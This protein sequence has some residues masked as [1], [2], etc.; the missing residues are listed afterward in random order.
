MLTLHG[1][2]TSTYCTTCRMV[3]SLKGVTDFRIEPNAPHSAEQD[4]RHPWGKVPALTHDGFT[5]Y[6]TSAITTYL[7]TLFP[8]P[9]L[10]P[11]DVK[12]LARMTQW[13]SAYCDNV[14]K[15]TFP[16]II[17]RLIV[18]GRGGTPDEDLVART[19][20]AAPATLAVFDRALAET[21]WL[22]GDR[23]TLADLFIL[24]NLV[25]FGAT[26]EG[27][28]I[29]SQLPHLQGM[30]DRAMANPQLAATMA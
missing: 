27:K 30:V 7:D 1:T 10:Q 21:P 16:I 29:M 2:P 22:A 28:A 9:P 19:A 13:I 8:Q 26:P 5:V 12:A 17:E 15:V 3:L 20:E 14:P 25:F 6:E 23:M 11:A 18:P 4:A 24:P